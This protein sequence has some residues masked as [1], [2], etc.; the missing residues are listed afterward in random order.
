MSKL[1]HEVLMDN[2]FIIDL[3]AVKAVTFIVSDHVF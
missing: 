3:L 1:Q 2:L